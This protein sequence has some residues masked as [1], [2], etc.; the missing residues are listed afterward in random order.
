V[1]TLIT[2]AKETRTFRVIMTQQFFKLLSYN[3]VN[4]VLL[5]NVTVNRNSK[6]I[7]EYCLNVYKES[8]K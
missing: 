6:N 7:L 2:S 1:M 3:D 5:C 4:I 8:A